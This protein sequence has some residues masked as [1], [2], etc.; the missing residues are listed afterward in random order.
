MINIILIK[1][2]I[3]RTAEVLAS[4]IVLLLELCRTVL[5]K[6]KHYD[7][8]IKIIKKLTLLEGKDLMKYLELMNN[9]ININAN[10][11][12]NEQSIL[13]T[14][15]IKV[16]SIM[17]TENDKIAFQ[18]ILES[19]FPGNE[20]EIDMLKILNPSINNHN[21]PFNDIKQFNI[22]MKIV[23]YHNPKDIEILLQMWQELH[24]ICIL[25]CLF[26]M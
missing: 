21:D 18:G 13:V 7:F 15:L 2:Y 19:V 1:Q 9:E 4:K 11:I 6:Q 17:L 16:L 5:S 3:D 23:F 24:I 22:C 14:S 25:I 26:I 10:K 12:N 20:K 8:D